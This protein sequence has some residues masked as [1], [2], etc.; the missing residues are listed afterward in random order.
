MGDIDVFDTTGA[1]PGNPGTA[2]LQTNWGLPWPIR[3][4]FVFAYGT[5]FYS[6][7]GIGTA[8]KR[9]DGWRFDTANPTSFDNRS[10]M[11]MAHGGS[12][13]KA[14]LNGKVYN[15]SGT[16]GRESVE[17]YD[18]SANTWNIE[19]SMPHDRREPYCAVLTGPTGLDELVVASGYDT[20]PQSVLGWT[21]IATIVPASSGT[22]NSYGGGSSPGTANISVSG[23]TVSVGFPGNTTSGIVNVSNVPKTS[24]PPLAGIGFKLAG[25]VYDITT[26]VTGWTT[27][28]ITLPYNGTNPNVTPR[29]WNSQTN[30]WDAI[31]SPAPIVDL[32]NHTVTFVT[33]SLSPFALDDDPTP[34]PASSP[35]SLALVGAIGFGLLVAAFRRR[36]A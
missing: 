23:G 24:L 32:T 30:T 26:N 21:D 27:L 17:Q 8:G 34:V 12:G 2:Q 15:P 10:P 19:P 5:S 18:I 25:Q 31:T 4:S 6:F 35:W 22:N 36:V 3:N 20:S 16:N 28:T 11:I 29:H 7:G 1:G 9:P 14:A 13:S 33:S